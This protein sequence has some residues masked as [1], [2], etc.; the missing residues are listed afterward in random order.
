MNPLI[1]VVLP[2]YNRAD[3]LGQAIGS[4]IAQTYTDWELIIWDDGSTD[5]TY[6]VVQSFN[7]QRIKYFRA[8]NH[9]MSFALN[10]G[11]SRANG[12]YI[13]F[14]DDDDYWMDF[15]LETQM[16]IFLSHPDIE[17]IFGNFINI[18]S[19][20]NGEK[21]AFISNKKALK[22]LEILPL[23]ESVFKIIDGFQESITY[24][25]YIAFDTVVMKRSTI[26]EIGEFNENLRN[27]QDFEYW[28][29]FGLGKRQA[30]F[31]NKKLMTRVKIPGSL[32]GRSI[33]TSLWRLRSLD[34]CREISE[35]QDGHKTVRLLNSAYR[36]TWQNL[37]YQYSL[38]KDEK[39]MTQSFLKALGYGFRFGTLRLYLHGL[40]N[41]R[42]K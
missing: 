2:T 21:D 17:M 19:E 40:S 25:N 15:K 41:I 35:K 30:A 3:L 28:W 4:V 36:N 34:S 14:I 26:E 1:S 29:R 31:T 11:I 9:G 33:E 37:I 42:L 39:G 10:Q 18:N 16:A 23:G 22:K 24:V 6:R 8:Q 5:N 7:D 32:S 12:S 20:T 38:Q 27:G 13:G